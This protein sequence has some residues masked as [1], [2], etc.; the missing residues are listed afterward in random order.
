MNIRTTFLYVT[1]KFTFTFLIYVNRK[2]KART[3]CLNFQ[4]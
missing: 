4:F 1:L 3:G 2:N